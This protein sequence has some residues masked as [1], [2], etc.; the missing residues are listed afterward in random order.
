MMALLKWDERE[1]YEKLIMTAIMLGVIVALLW[2][3]LIN[4]VLNSKAEARTLSS[5]SL[6]FSPM[7]KT[8]MSGLTKFQ[9]DSF[10]A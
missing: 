5:G 7:E 10:T 1:L 3:L 9:P 8:L 4:P 6:V 2:L